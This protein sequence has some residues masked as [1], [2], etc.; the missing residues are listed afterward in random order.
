MSAVIRTFIVSPLGVMHIDASFILLSGSDGIL[1]ILP[2]H[3][4]LLASLC[5]GITEITD[6]NETKCVIYTASGIVKIAEDNC[7]IAVKDFFPSEDL[8][9]PEIRA[10]IASRLKIVQDELR[11]DPHIALRDLLNEEESFLASL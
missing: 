11:N 9:K 8:N 6:K 3:S 1:G 2:G 4:N 10:R 7:T 5:R